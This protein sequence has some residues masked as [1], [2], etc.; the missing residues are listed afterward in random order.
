MSILNSP[1]PIHTHAHIHVHTH[2]HTQNG[3]EATEAIRALGFSGLIIGLTGNALDDDVANFIKSGEPSRLV[4]G[5][6]GIVVIGV[7]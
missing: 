2:T 7:G 4:I 1:P 3:L 6:D 5:V